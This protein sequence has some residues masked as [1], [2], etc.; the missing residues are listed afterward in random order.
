[1]NKP[2]PVL[3]QRDCAVI[4]IRRLPSNP[5]KEKTGGYYYKKYSLRLFAVDKRQFSI[6]FQFLNDEV[7]G[8][9]IPLVVFHTGCMAEETVKQSFLNKKNML[10]GLT[11]V[12]LVVAVAASVYFYMQYYQTQK[13]LKN[14]TLAAQQQTQALLSAVGNLID[15][16]QNET[17][18]IATVSD[19]TKLQGQP[20]FAKAQNG[21]KVLIYTNAKKAI[22]YRPS[23]NK[24]IDVAPVNI[25]ANVTPTPTDVVKKVT[26]KPTAGK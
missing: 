4:F 3:G 19:V 22:L 13:L 18:T 26:P 24:I 6:K 25:G 14:P 16:P 5:Q 11:A 2:S 1:M 15:L 8:L 10:M 21:D 17:P 12:V 20:F 9:T 23:E 7:M